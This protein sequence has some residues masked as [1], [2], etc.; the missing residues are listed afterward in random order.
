LS[1]IEIKRTKARPAVTMREKVEL[2]D[3][4]ETMGR[5][6][7]GVADFLQEKGVPIAGPPFAFYNSW[8]PNAV[9][10]ECGFPVEKEIKATGKVHSFTLPSVKAVVTVHK[11]PY[12]EMTVTYGHVMDWMKENK[13]SPA[14]Y[15][16]EVYLNDPT[17]TSMEEL[18]TEIVWPIK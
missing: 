17:S 9:D 16:W 4:A 7:Q 15:M 3:L 5:M 6:Y 18:L 14:D 13:V 10:V 1:G 11:G 2:K 8:P 12:Q